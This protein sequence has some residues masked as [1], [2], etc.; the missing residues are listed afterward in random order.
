MNV[1]VSISLQL[2]PLLDRYSVFTRRG[3]T[4]GLVRNVLPSAKNAF[5]LSSHTL[6][7]MADSLKLGCS[8]PPTRWTSV[9][10]CPFVDLIIRPCLRPPP[11]AV[12]PSSP[13]IRYT[14]VWPIDL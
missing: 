8:V 9:Q 14:C 11:I 1:F 7:R 5:A 3:L 12:P 6:A 4:W 2:V 10:S 13:P